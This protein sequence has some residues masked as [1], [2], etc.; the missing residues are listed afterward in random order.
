MR[1]EGEGTAAELEW[2]NN[3]FDTDYYTLL[4]VRNESAV[5]F[6]ALGHLDAY[7]YNNNAYT[8]LYKQISEDTS[9]EEYCR[10]MQLS[11]NN[12]IVAIILCIIILLLLLTGYY[13]LYFRHRL[14]Y[15]YN[16]EQVLEIN[17]QV[18]T[19]SLL[20]E[21]A[22]KDIAESLVN[23]MFEGINELIAIDVLGI[24]VYSE[25]SHNLK[26]S[27]SL[28]D[29]GNE[30]MRE[31]MTRC[32]ETQTVYWTEKIALNAFLC[33]WKPEEKIVAPVYWL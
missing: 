3:H 27:F 14:L 26:C 28:S 22:D 16:L 30:D 29:E 7:R 21:Q 4:D 32:F 18:F 9:L 19:G 31:L 6:L 12:K 8:A 1:L 20:N 17:K 2:F 15:R 25:D 23:A 13:L 11:A 10:Q 33:G 24:A 5:A